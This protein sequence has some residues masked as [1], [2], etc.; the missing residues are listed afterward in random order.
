[1]WNEEWEKNLMGVAIERVKGKV[2]SKQY[3]IFDLYVVKRWPVS[4]VVRVLRINPARVYL[5]KHRV[6]NL[7]KK[8]VARLQSQESK[9]RK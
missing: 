3:Q 2:D 9:L 8:E 6:G 4:K 5:T 7:I 1:M